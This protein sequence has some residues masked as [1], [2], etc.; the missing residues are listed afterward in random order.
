M[1]INTDGLVLVQ[2]NKIGTDTH[3]EKERMRE[4][5]R[6]GES[7]KEREKITESE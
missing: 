2:I 6:W 4:N 3:N 7:K 5:E 1:L